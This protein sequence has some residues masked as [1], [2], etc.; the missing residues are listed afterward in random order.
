MSR[1]GAVAGLDFGMTNSSL[2]TFGPS[3]V[4]KPYIMKGA[5]SWF[6]PT[7]V[8][9][10]GLARW[11]ERFVEAFL[12]KFVIGFGARETPGFVEN[13]KI[14]LPHLGTLEEGN[15][16][17]REEYKAASKFLETLFTKFFKDTG[18]SHFDELV[19]TVPESWLSGAQLGGV[20]AL[21]HI[22]SGIRVQTPRI[23]SEPVAAACYFAHLHLEAEGR[24]F[25]GHVLIYDHGGSTLDLCVARLTGEQVHTITRVGRSGE[26]GTLGFGGV[27]FDKLVFDKVAARNPRIAALEGEDR[28]RWLHEF[29]EMK[30]RAV[31]DI[32]TACRPDAPPEARA[33]R[34]FSLKDSETQVRVSDLL[35]VFEGE[36]SDRIREDVNAVLA[37]A[38]QLDSIDTT[39]PDRFRVVTV[40]G[41]SEFPPVQNL[42]RE[43]FLAESGTADVLEAH[44]VEN[45]DRWL[46]VAKGAC[47]V[48]SGTSKV[49]P[50]CPLTFGVTAYVKTEPHKFPL[51]ELGRPIASYEAENYLDTE[52]EL[53]R[54]TTPGA[55]SLEFFIDRAGVTIPLRMTQTFRD[56]LPDYGRA[57]WWHLGCVL[58]EGTALLLMKSNL[59]GRG[60]IRMGNFMSMMK[61]ELEGAAKAA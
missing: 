14:K 43:I 17:G 20:N 46:A 45:D 37:Q 22:L 48:A 23:L 11:V 5:N 34:A 54:L 36:F 40:G 1:R 61:G 39:R 15:R 21:K 52:F 10:T 53:A 59:G 24:P 56:M 29:E 4:P 49:K 27:Q 19:V 6:V 7:V 58:D 31:E 33:G 13:F 32:E 55:D 42:M 3:K 26:D 28:A 2:C 18:H 57:S 44:F 50:T 8:A 35:E 60:R 41:F 38:K 25:D 51:L 30:R 16:H 47:L 12:D 9:N